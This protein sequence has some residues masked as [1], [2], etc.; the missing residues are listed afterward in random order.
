MTGVDT[1]AA[2][3][4]SCDA[5]RL[6]DP[7]KVGQKVNQVSFTK[8][9]LRGYETL[10]CR[11][12]KCETIK[13]LLKDMEVQSDYYVKV[14]TRIWSGT[15]LTAMYQSTTLT[16]NVALETA[17]PE[18][19]TLGLKQLPVVLTISKPGE[20]ADVPV[21]VIVGSV[22]GGLALLALAVGLL[23]KFGFFKRKY[24]QLQKDMDDEGQSP[25]QADP[26]VL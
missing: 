16:A 25:A 2:G 6:V 13:C 20:T 9:S 18:L 19:L 15:F 23:W 17:D 3:A 12:C 1:G 10:D 8:E 7:L 4:V 22:I 14:K 21:G 24:K 11:N 26:G 5:S